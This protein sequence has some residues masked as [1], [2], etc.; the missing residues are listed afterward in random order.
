MP[1]SR[2]LAADAPDFVPF[3]MMTPAREETASRKHK[4]DGR[5]ARQSASAQASRHEDQST[6]SL[7]ITTIMVAGI[8]S[9]HTSETF[10]AQLDGWGLL[11][12]YNFFFMPIDGRSGM[13]LGYAI[14]NFIDPTFAAFCQMVSAQYGF[15]GTA[16]PYHVQGLEA[17]MQQ[18]KATSGSEKSG[19]QPAI[20]QTPTPSQWAING[21]NTMLN[22]IN[23]KFS[24]QIREQFYK[25]RMCA[26]YKKNKCALASECPFAH[27]P[28]ELQ[29]VPDLAKTKLCY[30]FF[31]QQCN[32]S[33][34]KFAHGYSELRATDTIY[35]TELCRW[36]TSGGCRAGGS[37]RYAHGVE[38]LRTVMPFPAG[39]AAVFAATPEPQNTCPPKAGDS[40][41][42]AHGVEKPKHVMPFSAGAAAAF[43][44]P[45]GPPSRRPQEAFVPTSQSASAS[46]PSPTPAPAP[47]STPGPVPSPALKLAQEKRASPGEQPADDDSA[48]DGFSDFGFSDISSLPIGGVEGIPLRQTTAPAY[49]GRMP[50]MI[51][52]G[53]DG[54]D[55]MLMVKGTFME[56]VQVNEEPHG[57]RMRRS[58]SDSDL[59]QLS[60]MVD[61]PGDCGDEAQ[62][63]DR[64]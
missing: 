8:P 23:P 64:E 15:E 50:R 56:A 30:N 25:T 48:Y 21:V 1:S 26:F 24:P 36:W 55:I 43:P 20:I 13:G 62:D 54:G 39:A 59:P 52:L 37:C 29:P 10:R 60:E 3:S 57:H 14:I 61:T 17:N 6:K 44:A 2:P 11:G 47:A 18:W 40:C 32:D 51:S 19:S 49:T 16:T 35:K 5:K 34:C 53:E 41:Q 42:N 9:H 4:K 46:D 33:R 12:T 38:E 7:P 63:F 28:R 22:P 58:W 31:R 45:P 27:D